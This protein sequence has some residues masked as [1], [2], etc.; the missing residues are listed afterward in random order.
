MKTLFIPAKSKSE[1][2]KSKIKEISKKLPRNIAIVYSVQYEK[3]AKEISE[4][5]SRDHI[6]TQFKQVLGCSSP[7]FQK[8]QAV[9][10]IGDGKFHA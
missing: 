5:L 8:T 7:K 3:Q 6:I 2:D 10:L 4:I 1:V 9:L